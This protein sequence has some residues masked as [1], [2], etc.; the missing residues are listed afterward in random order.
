MSLIYQFEMLR[1]HQAKPPHS[2][3]I[4]SQLGLIHPKLW[5]VVRVGGA[6]DLVSPLRWA[7]FFYTPA[8]TADEAGVEASVLS[9]P[10]TDSSDKLQHCATRESLLRKHMS[11][12]TGC[13]K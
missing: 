1:L 6:A 12:H 8:A 10:V 7:K 2:L 13:Y 11:K 4:N 5:K 9:D 3:R